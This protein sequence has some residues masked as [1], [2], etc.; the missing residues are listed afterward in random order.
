MNNLIIGPELL[1]MGDSEFD[2]EVWRNLAEKIN[3]SKTQTVLKYN[4]ELVPMELKV[5]RN[6]LGEKSALCELLQKSGFFPS[7]KLVAFVSMTQYGIVR[8]YFAFTILYCMNRKMA[9]ISNER[10]EYLCSRLLDYFGMNSFELD[11]LELSNF[12]SPKK[13]C[14]LVL[15]KKSKFDSYVDVCVE[16]VVDFMNDYLCLDRDFIEKQKK[17]LTSSIF[18]LNGENNMAD[19]NVVL[20]QLFEEN[21]SNLLN[22]N[23]I[24]LTNKIPIASVGNAGAIL[25]F[26]TNKFLESYRR[27]LLRLVNTMT[28][29]DRARLRR[30]IGSNSFLKLLNRFPL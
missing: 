6:L 10:L 15:D 30:M 29:I 2:Q 13:D 19:D 28:H 25:A 7:D 23:A 24:C 12:G 16:T 8:F 9:S 18:F 14:G 1:L 17:K 21:L 3:N 22:A 11:S 20:F 5:A 4:K 26:S 27:E